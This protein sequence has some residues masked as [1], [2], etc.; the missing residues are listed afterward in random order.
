M[1]PVKTE[2][3][4]SQES[5]VVITQNTQVGRQFINN[6]TDIT[7]HIVTLLLLTNHTTLLLFFHQSRWLHKPCVHERCDLCQRGRLVQLHLSG[8]LRW[9]QM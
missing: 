1:V 6:N 3:S 9:Q 5:L 2:K 7:Q 4:L 8:W